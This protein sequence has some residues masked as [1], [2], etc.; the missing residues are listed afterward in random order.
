MALADKKTNPIKK[1][2]TFCLFALLILSFG[3]WGIGDIFQGPQ[4][5]YSVAQVGKVSIGQQEF[6]RNLRQELARLAPQFGGRLDIE[7]AQAFGVVQQVMERLTTRA[8]FE[9]HASDMGLVVTDHQ[10]LEQIRNLPAFQDQVSGRFDRFAYE[11]ALR[12]SGLSEEAFL[13][14]LTGDIQRQQVVSAISGAAAM[15]RA[16]AEALYRYSA[17]T[18]SAETVL[19]R[20]DSRAM[21]R[22]APTTTR[23]PTIS[24]RRSTAASASCRSVLPP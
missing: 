19:F 18:R 15:P 8:L 17:E 24:W 6:S 10:L 16:M 5:A 1:F 11:G 22:S 4:H 20:N 9:Q 14:G 13:Q 2:V 12:N 23:T 3:V 7:Q 21:I